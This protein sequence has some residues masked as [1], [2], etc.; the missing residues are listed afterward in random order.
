MARLPARSVKVAEQEIAFRVEDGRIHPSPLALTIDGHALAL[1]GSV[2][3][4]A[5]LDYKATIPVTADL[6]GREA[7]RLLEGAT[8]ALGIGGTV[9]RPALAGDAFAKAM[10][11]LV[12][13]AAANIV[14]EEGREAVRDLQERGEEALRD[15][16]RKHRR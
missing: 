2:G 14:R 6:V 16:L 7:F 4:D 10:A 15:L 3:L 13:A 12:K 9:S 1:T 5:T 11:S 8:L